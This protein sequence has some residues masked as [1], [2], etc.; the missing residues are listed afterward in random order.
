[1]IGRQS[2]NFVT[3]RNKGMQEVQRL[4][5]GSISINMALGQEL[6]MNDSLQALSQLQSLLLEG[7]F[8]LLNGGCLLLHLDP[9]LLQIVVLPLQLSIA[10]T[11]LRIA[12][13]T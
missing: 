3:H 10:L 6:V 13:R 12:I 8:L 11:T 5:N 9:V 4:V 2:E 7:L 1:M